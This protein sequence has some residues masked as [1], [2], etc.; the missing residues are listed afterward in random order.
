M[1]ADI[2]RGLIALNNRFY[3]EHAASFSATRS[4]PWAGW[5]QLLDELRSAGGLSGCSKLSALDLA[6]GNLRFERFLAEALPACE[7]RVHAVDSCPAL[8]ER[9]PAMDAARIHYQQLDILEELLSRETPPHAMPRKPFDESAYD[10]T[11]CFGFMHHVPGAALRQRLL[12]LLVD[13][14]APHGFI[15]LSCW[16]FMGDA[17]LAAK[18][19]QAD[20]FA[21]AAPPFPGFSLHALE[22]HDHFLG[23]Q[24]DARP[25]RYCHH[26]A[27]AD[28]DNLVAH[29]APRARELARWSADGRSGTLN[30]YLLL[31]R[32]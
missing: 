6:C 8:I 18:A 1:D 29:V 3:A 21:S 7:L 31:Q 16:Q 27:D 2:A 15:A 26:F 14:T 32:S 12:D 30:R 22:E 11:V 5:S 20:D 10:L 23:W 28:I 9:A 4:A 24:D 17:R 13:A 19:L 25:L